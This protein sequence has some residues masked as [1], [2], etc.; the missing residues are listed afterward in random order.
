MYV[1]VRRYLA[2]DCTGIPAKLLLYRRTGYVQELL[3]AG[4][5]S[6]DQRSQTTACAM[7]TFHRSSSLWSLGS[8]AARMSTPWYIGLPALDTSPALLIRSARRSACTA[9]EACCVQQH[10]VAATQMC[11]AL[12]DSTCGFL[13]AVQLSFNLCCRRLCLS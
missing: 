9:K 10:V 12:C 8:W 7:R 4:M 11:Q 3:S 13:S 5:C 1:T 2:A 6:Q